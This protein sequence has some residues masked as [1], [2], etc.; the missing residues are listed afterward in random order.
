LNYLYS[1]GDRLEAR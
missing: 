1:E